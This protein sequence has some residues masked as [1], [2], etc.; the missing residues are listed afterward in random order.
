MIDIIISFSRASNNPEYIIPLAMYVAEIENSYERDAMVSRIISSLSEDIAH[1]NT[2]DP[3]ETMA[4]LL[5]RNE[6]GKS[7][8]VILKIRYRILRM[9]SDPYIK[10]R[11]LCKL[12]DLLIKIHHKSQAQKILVEVYNSLEG[13]LAEY[14]KILILSYLATLY[15]Q[16]DPQIASD[17]LLLGIQRLEAVEFDKD[18]VSRRQIVYAIIRIHAIRPD[19]K[20]FEIALQVVRENKQSC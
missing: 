17:Y 13:L 12:A 5:R 7:N 16:I 10:L 18:A 11:G 19:S 9:I 15:C 1:P 6:R 4:Y 3:Y 20:W 2:T 14:Q 8:Q